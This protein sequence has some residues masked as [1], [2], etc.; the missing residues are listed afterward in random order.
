MTLPQKKHSNYIYIHAAIQPKAQSGLDQKEKPKAVN[1]LQPPLSLW[2]PLPKSIIGCQNGNRLSH[3]NENSY[4]PLSMC[5][6]ASF[7]LTIILVKESNCV[8]KLQETQL[9]SHQDRIILYRNSQG[10]M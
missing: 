7:K 4:H 9:M 8:L 3:Q 5:K 1:Y 2:Y 6:S 10:N